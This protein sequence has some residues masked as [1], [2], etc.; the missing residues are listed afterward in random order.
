MTPGERGRTQ[1]RFLDLS[2]MGVGVEP[3]IAD[4][5]LA[6][7]RDMLRFRFNRGTRRYS[8]LPVRKTRLGGGVT[9]PSGDGEKPRFRPTTGSLPG[10]PPGATRR[11]G[12]RR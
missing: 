2:P 4:H 12:P 7:I 8:H 6:F 3:I 1:N 5:D 9:G 10:R 11:W